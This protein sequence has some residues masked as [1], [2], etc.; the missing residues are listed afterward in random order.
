[1]TTSGLSIS[2]T[3]TYVC[4]NGFDL[5]GDA[6]ATCIAID[7]NS[8]AFMPLAPTCIRECIAVRSL[9]LLGISVISMASEGSGFCDGTIEID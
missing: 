2:S 1:M 4:N 6:M 3:A 8:A 9:V 5:D 7:E